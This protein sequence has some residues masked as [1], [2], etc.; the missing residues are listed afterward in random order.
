MIFEKNVIKEMKHFSEPTAIIELMS[1]SCWGIEENTIVKFCKPL[2]ST[3]F[4]IHCVFH[5]IAHTGPWLAASVAGVSFINEFASYAMNE[6]ASNVMQALPLNR[7]TRQR[8]TVIDYN[9]QILRIYKWLLKLHMWP[10][11]KG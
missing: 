8:F 3:T 2:T 1:A 9:S 10:T 5:Q 11:V 6:F 7:H 4:S